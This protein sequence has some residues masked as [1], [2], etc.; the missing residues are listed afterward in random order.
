MN[1][2][3]FVGAHVRAAGKEAF[4]VKEDLLSAFTDWRQKQQ[5][6][7]QLSELEKARAQL[8]S[9]L[10]AADFRPVL[11][12]AR[13]SEQG[14][15]EDCWVRWSL[16]YEG[17]HRTLPKRVPKSNHEGKPSDMVIWCFH[18]RGTYTRE[19]FNT[20]LRQNVTNPPTNKEA[21]ETLLRKAHSRL[22]SG[23]RK[24]T[25]GGNCTQF[26]AEGM[27]FNVFVDD[28]DLT[29][30][31]EVPFAKSLDEHAVFSAPD[32]WADVRAGTG[33]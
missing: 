17:G 15:F 2:S 8:Q 28:A 12:V 18:L 21:I 27:V 32:V 11:K 7:M 4:V 19:P 30:M 10:P 16:E 1:L 5:P 22:V 26:T 25:P 14:T 3:V 20:F 6:T 24:D 13:G 31:P 9:A 33:K 29:G 23:S